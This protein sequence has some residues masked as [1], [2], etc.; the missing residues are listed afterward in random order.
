MNITKTLQAGW[1][2]ATLPALTLVNAQAQS[3]TNADTGG[4][5]TAGA[6][7]IGKTAPGSASV[8]VWDTNITAVTPANATSALG[9]NANWGGIQI[10]NP[11]EPIV[12]SADGNTL[13]LGASGIDMS[14]ATN[15]LTLNCP[16]V[17][18]AN[19]IW[20][21]TNG[22][23]LTLGGVVSGSGILTLN[24]NGTTV[25][26][27][28]NTYTAG[29]V[30]NGGIVAPA[31]A[32]SFGA[33]SSANVGQGAVTNNGG[34][35][36]L[37]LFPASGIM[38]N[39]FVVNGTTIIDTGSLG[40]SDVLS[41]SWL[42]SGTILVSNAVSGLTLTLGGN[43]VGNGDVGT[44]AGFTG[45][46]T[47]VENNSGT[48]S[49]GTLRFNNGGANNN[50]GNPGMTL[51]LG[52]GSVTFKERDTG[53]TVSFGALSGG[54]NTALTQSDTYSIGALNL[55]TTFAGQ[56]Q[57][58]SALTKVGTGTFT[59]TGNNPYTG[60]TSI[61]AGV[62]QIGDGVTAGTGTLGSGAVV[63]SAS[64]VFNRPDSYTVANSISGSGTVT[65]QAGGTIN[66]SGANTSSGP[67]MISNGDLILTG[68]MSCPIIV[69]SAG[70]FDV[71]QTSFN[72]NQTLSGFGT[73]TGLV[74]AVS[75]QISPGGTGTAGTLTFASGL[76]ESGNVNNNIALSAP[77]GTN[78]L[79]NVS[80]ALTL[81]GTN[82]ITVSA[83][84]GGAI[85]NGTYPLIAYGAL[86]SG[87]LTNFNLTVVGGVTGKLTNLTTTTPRQIAVIITPG[88]RP[89]TN[90]TWVGD[91]GANNWDTTTSNWVSGT[92]R[93]AFLAGDSVMFND[94]GAPNTNVDLAAVSPLLPASVVVS[95]AA[96]QYTFTGNDFIGGSTGL[97]K[98]N[99]GI[100]TVLT[101]NTYTGQTIIGGGMLEVMVMTNGGSP[102][103]LGAATSDPSN[104]VFYGS[105]LRYSGPSAGTD[106]GATLNLAGGTVDVTNPA[107]V[108]TENGLLTGSG[109]LAK[110]GLGTL[111][112]AGANTY[113]GGTIISNGVLATANDTANGAGFGPATSPISFYG[114]TLTL[115]NSTFDDGSTTYTFNNPLNVPAGQTG[116]LNLFLRG[117]DNGALTGGGIL[118]LTANGQRVAFAGNW[119]AFS[120]TL[121]ITGNFRIAN[122]AGYSN[123]VI[124]LLGASDLDGGTATGIYSSSPTFDIGELDAAGAATLGAISKP[125]PNPTWRVGWKNTTSTFD[126]TIENPSG[127][128]AAI[129][130]V[131]TG[132]WFLAGQNTFTG[133]TTVSNG[134]LALTNNASTFQDGS[135]NQST[136][137]F[138]NT[139]AILD[140]SGTSTGLLYLASG[141]VL[142]GGGTITGILDTTAGSTVSPGIGATGTLSVTNG[143]TLGGAVNISIDH[144]AA[145][146]V[147]G[148]LAAPNIAM[149][150][151]TILTV[152]QGTNDLETGDIFHLFNT[153]Y[154]GSANL[155]INP[156]P[157]T[158]PV[159]GVTYVWNTN[160][161]ASSGTLILTTG[162]PAVN[163]IPTNLVYSVSGG[164]INLS[165]PSNQLGWALQT[166]SIN[167]GVGADWF[168]LPGSTSVTSESITIQKTGS[169]FFRLQNSK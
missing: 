154:T 128:V 167:I 60:V 86:S 13:T 118:N 88:A 133:S 110:A 35:L 113:L 8:A 119:S 46:I 54:S 134:V 151:G 61:S 43:G 114:G 34:T 95:N 78:D 123:A 72:L 39:N 163:L 1:L 141:Q 20:D 115:Y 138:I 143:V 94:S 116:Y 104:L 117:T 168:T 69:Q 157:A 74:T 36:L 140:V 136:N 6:S 2:C 109:A 142:S 65:I 102:S 15:S 156:L 101:A 89:A 24:G 75:G 80:N 33:T 30:I 164:K 63:N 27:A 31:N 22:Q 37:S 106:R 99:S 66:Y 28:A 76:T 145:G 51:N 32:S 149:S 26:D 14:L 48:P 83:L 121:N 137:I 47:I 112:L 53:S 16:V 23:T 68:G 135:I 165:W 81:A 71:S 152:S 3:V 146:A 7:W 29:T 125:T 73:V 67:T 122:T 144:T 132:A 111:T 25:L 38:V 9:A 5:L 70:T 127:G 56:I 161:L 120:G 58:S 108:L 85:P 41:G 166:N 17:L 93:F 126:G 12:I 44:F 59:L 103:G 77:G 139:G 91:G 107:T 153:G 11:A 147:S 57:G 4:N 169:V 19:Q 129:T 64:L 82:T 97:T 159:S 105:A 96:Q 90:L 92:T 87:G 98:T 42:G 40:Q 50:V 84:G 49:A 45:T 130:K 79:I 124:N 52:V 131:G 160:N 148:A 150:P 158:G 55:N 100:L 10:L 155:A 21:V 18:G 162:A 62:L